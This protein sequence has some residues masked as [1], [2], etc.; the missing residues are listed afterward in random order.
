MFV[1]KFRIKYAHSSGL[2]DFYQWE[3]TST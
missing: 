3:E 2:Y 1:K